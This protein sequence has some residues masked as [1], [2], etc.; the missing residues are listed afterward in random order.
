MEQNNIRKDL[1]DTAGKAGL[2]LGLV[3]TAY[4]FATQ[5]MA[6]TAGFMTS[7]LSFILWA[8]KFGGC[9][10]LMSFFMKRFA[11][12]HPEVDNKTTFRLGMATAFLSALVYSGAAFANIAFISGDLMTEQIELMMQQMGSMMDSN[13]MTLMETYLENLPVITFFSSMLYC[14]VFGT[15]LSFIL[16][17]NIPNKDPFA[18]YK[19]DQQ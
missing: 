16:S 7:I 12:D 19:P 1:A 13:S 4:M 10:W 6:G 11:A 8:A 5:L 2:V 14:F 17:R 3:S 18:D 9:I 15:V